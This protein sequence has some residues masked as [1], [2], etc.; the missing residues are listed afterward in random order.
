MATQLSADERRGGSTVREPSR[1][2][3]SPSAGVSKP[4]ATSP[5]VVP[6]AAFEA[7]ESA[8]PPA[9]AEDAQEEEQ[10]DFRTRFVLFSAIPSW[11]VSMVVHAILLLIMGLIS[12][13][14]PGQ[15][16]KTLLV[17]LPEVDAEAIEDVEIQDI[18]LPDIEEL[19]LDA[20]VTTAAASSVESTLTATPLVSAMDS[21]GTPVELSAF[22][23]RVAPRGELLGTVGDLGGSALGGRGSQMRGQ[24]LAKYGGNKISEEAVARALEWLAA[25]QLPNGAWSFNHQLCKTCRGACGD[26]GSLATSVNGATAMALLP[27]L[28]AGQ[29]HKDGEYQKVVE[30]GLYFLTTNMKLRRGQGG[31]LTDEGGRFYSHGLASIVLCEAYAMTNDRDL[32]EPAQMALDYIVYAQHE[33]GGWRYYPRTP[34]DTSVVGWQLMALKSGHMAY[35]RVPGATV[36]KAS[37]FLDSVQANQ[38][39]TYGYMGPGEAP[40][41]TAIGLLCRMYLGWAKEHPS[42]R[43]GVEFLDKTGPLEEDM[44]YN[45][46]A[47]QVLRHHEGPEW[48]RWNK[49]MRDWL[50]ETQAKRGHQTGSWMMRDGHGGGSGGRLYCTSLATMILEVYYRH[51][52]IY[53]QQAADDDFPL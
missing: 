18:E 27:F 12:L 34:G 40:A 7:A 51:L 8:S 37:Y 24:M 4:A 23:E 30:R 44:Y 15:G 38:G 49:K 35:L 17:S 47:T 31:D 3:R 9:P 32:M 41:T 10:L 13:P 11:L 21:P 48:D 33:G 42:L 43:A 46:Y 53:G 45:Y 25:H 28:G 39:A 29:T 19:S 16:T 36:V 5:E 1:S 6:E 22:A 14:L 20:S 2:G 50:V 52:P 26:P